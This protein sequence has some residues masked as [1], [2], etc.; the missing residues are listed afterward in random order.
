VQGS[1]SEHTAEAAGRAVDDVTLLA[2]A[3][4][5]Q[6]ES[7]VLREESIA[8]RTERLLA[9]EVEHLRIAVETRDVI[10][11]AKGILMERHKITADEAFAMLRQRSQALNVKLASIAEHLASTGELR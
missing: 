4:A 7:K 8:T 2:R 6:A 9:H 5:A 3:A 10:G 1:T 11:Q